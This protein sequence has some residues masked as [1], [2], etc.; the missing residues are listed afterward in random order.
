MYRGG[1][2]PLHE[3]GGFW[4]GSEDVLSAGRLTAGDE[5][6]AFPERNEART[7]RG[8]IGGKD[9]GGQLLDATC[10]NGGGSRRADQGG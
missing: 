5:S 3:D 10:T 9:E 4:R 7:K 1:R 8:V 2:A 6:T